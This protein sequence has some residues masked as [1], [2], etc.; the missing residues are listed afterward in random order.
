MV[1]GIVVAAH[2]DRLDLAVLFGVGV[3]LV[4]GVILGSF[5]DSRRCGYADHAVL[6]KEAYCFELLFGLILF[7]VLII[8]RP[9]DRQISDIVAACRRREVEV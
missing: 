6:L 4:D 9:H 5:R 7:S 2:E 1:G 8:L 3:K